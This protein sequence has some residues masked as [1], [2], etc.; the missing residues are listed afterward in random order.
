MKKYLPLFVSFWVANS[1]LL[2]LA[3]AMF[4]QYF[5]LGTYRMSAIAAAIAAGGVWTLL[6]M[7]VDPLVKRFKLK[8]NGVSQMTVFYWL[9][10]FIALWITA[11]LAPYLGFGVSRFVWI[12]GLAFVANLV[13][14]TLWKIGKFKA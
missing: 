12:L 1:T 3:F 10:N 11:R 4:P 13:Q 5:M 6:I 7:L 14:F 8:V 2:Y 9:A